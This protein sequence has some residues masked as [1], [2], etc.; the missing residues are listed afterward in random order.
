MGKEL[1]VGG[2]SSI[3]GTG[4]IHLPEGWVCTKYLHPESY[5][6][7]LRLLEVKKAIA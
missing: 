5:A 3:V 2:H 6:A 4:A 7:Y 1:L